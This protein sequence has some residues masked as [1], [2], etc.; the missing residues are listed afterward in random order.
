MFQVGCIIIGL[1]LSLTPICE[2]PIIGLFFKALGG[3]S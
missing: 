3:I 1:G 2:V